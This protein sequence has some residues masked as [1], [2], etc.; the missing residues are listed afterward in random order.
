MRPSVTERLRVFVSGSSGPYGAHFAKLCLDKGHQIFSLEHNRRPN[1]SAALLGIKDKITWVSGDIR[2]TQLLATCMASFDIQAVAHFAALPLVRVATL[3]TQPVFDINVMGTVA[4]LDAVKQVVSGG[5]RVHFLMCST[6]K[7]YGDAGD[8]PY[9]ED[10]PLHGSSV[11]EASKVAAE[12]VCRAYQSQGLV[13]DLVV[14]RSSNVIARGDLAWRLLPNTCR[15]FLTNTPAK[16][17]TKGQYVREYLDVRDAVEAQYLLMLRADEYAGQAFNIGSGFQWTQE[18]AID[19]L[20]ENHFPEGIIIRTDPPAYH[21]IEISY[22]RLDCTKIKKALGWAP[23]I[24]LAESV[25]D[26][27]AWWR[28]HKALAPWSML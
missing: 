24:S 9:T 2:D 10:T 6:D 22:Q 4:I 26:L 20:R 12:A 28:E 19:H 14:S 27:V 5:R 17:F 3:V 8:V 1:D 15:Q 16:I 25:A 11:Y 21:R 7:V 13:P 18:E 23:E